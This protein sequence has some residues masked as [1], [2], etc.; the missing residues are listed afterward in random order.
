MS[1]QPDFII[2]ELLCYISN[3]IKVLSLETI[4][5]I[6]DNFY[7]DAAVEHAKQLLF[8]LPLFKDKEATLKF[9]TRKGG[10]KKHKNLEDII[11]KIKEVTVSELPLFVA[12]DLRQLPQP[13]MSP[14][15]AKLNDIQT[16]FSAITSTVHDHVKDTF[17]ESFSKIDKRLS[18][19]ESNT[20]FQSNVNP[21]PTT[22]AERIS[23]NPTR[24]SETELCTSSDKYCAQA[25]CTTGSPESNV[26]TMATDV[27]TGTDTSIT[28]DATWSSIV[29]Q[30]GKRRVVPYNTDSHVKAEQQ[31]QKQKKKPMVGKASATGFTSVKRKRIANVF[32]TRFSP[33]VDTDE[34]KDYLEEKLSLT[35][36]VERLQSKFSNYYSSFYI[37]AECDDPTVFMD[38]EI[39]PE[40]IYFRWYRPNRV[41]QKPDGEVLSSGEADNKSSSFLH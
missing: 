32:A 31:N 15:L 17:W 21:Q 29:R 23:S 39:W 40:G 26:I 36:S 1:E 11:T 18:L 28:T 19:L 16:N 33:E 10:N 2:N 24:A 34:L 22:L 7:S 30:G 41:V 37:K 12:K 6:C 5:T 14:I 38:P 20:S 27:N 13:H 8:S 3:E 35:V 25:I 4:V 9:I